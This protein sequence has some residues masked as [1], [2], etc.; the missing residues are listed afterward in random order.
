MRYT[1]L[2]FLGLALVACAGQDPGAES[3]SFGLVFAPEASSGCVSPGLGTHKLP[4]D[5]AYVVARVLGKD[6]AEA[7]AVTITQEDLDAGDGQFLFR[8]ITPGEWTLEVTGCSKQGVAT[9]RGTTRGVKVEAHRKSLPLVFM[10]PEG[11]LACIGGANQNPLTSYDGARFVSDGRVAFGAGAV[12]PS[13]RVIIAGGGFDYR[14]A[15][16]DL[17]L[18][19]TGVWEFRPDAGVFVPIYGPT[20]TRLALGEQRLGHGMVAL[21][22]DHILVIGGGTAAVLGG[23]GTQPPLSPREKVPAPIEILTLSTASSQS[24]KLDRWVAAFP[25]WAWSRGRV[26][27][28]GGMAASKASDQVMFVDPLDPSSAVFGTLSS[29][30]FGSV[31]RFLSTGELLV[32]GGFSGTGPAGPELVKEDKGTVE[33]W[34]LNVSG[35]PAGVLPTAFPLVEVLSD[36]GKQA[37]ILVALGTPIGSGLYG[38]PSAQNIWLLKLQGDGTRYDP[39]KAETA[40]VGADMDWPLVRSLVSVV[41]LGDG[42]LVAGG[43]KSFT[44]SPGFKDCQ[45]SKGVD[46]E[47]CFPRSIAFASLTP[48]GTGLALESLRLPH[49]RLGVTAV[50]LNKDQVLLLGGLAGFGLQ[51]PGEYDWVAPDASSGWKTPADWALSSG[52]ILTRAGAF[53]KGD[54]CSSHAP[55]MPK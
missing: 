23:S 38:Q 5:V 30:R 24:Q 18:G 25:A 21:D 15:S 8:G 19:G 1:Y 48:D 22:D 14:P 55:T 33:S 6:D 11:R 36:D 44:K 53:A 45:D 12:T 47:Y 26:A 7:S 35:P 46:L 49:G 40:V 41:S 52:F 9:W 13:G 43:V 32:V 34:M 4:G 20:G 29:P 10:L 27:L 50:A 42:L 37:T 31:A 16:G 51:A 17:L 39:S 54:V 28:A 2:A 3:S